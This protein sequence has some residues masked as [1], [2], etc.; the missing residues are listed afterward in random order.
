M[1]AILFEN[2][3]FSFV[4]LTVDIFDSLIR[5]RFAMIGHSDSPNLIEAVRIEKAQCGGSIAEIR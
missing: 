3:M 5:S 1:R 2:Q 4:D